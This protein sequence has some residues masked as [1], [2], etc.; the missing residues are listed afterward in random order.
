M[1]KYKKRARRSK[2]RGR[3]S[4]GKRRRSNRGSHIKTR[5]LGGLLVSDRSTIKLKW[6]T[7]YTTALVGGAYTYFF[8]ANSVYDP[9]PTGGSPVPP[10]GFITYMTLYRHFYVAGCKIMA[11]IANT[12]TTDSL[13]F[14]IYPATNPLSTA[15]LATK[16]P[17]EYPYCTTKLMGPLASSRSN[18]VV[19]KYMSTKKIY[20]LKTSSE[21]DF[22]G[23][24]ST[25]P[26]HLWYWNLFCQSPTTSTAPFT[27]YLELTFYCNFFMR[28]EMTENQ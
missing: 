5:K 20:G 11:K 7:F 9:D 21:S 28:E 18:A 14:G 23:T 22:Q 19:K 13:M 26:D 6:R 10:T 17:S 2:F 4:Y 15:D 8:N 3:R 27:V 1:P 24:T 12:S 16:V 25:S